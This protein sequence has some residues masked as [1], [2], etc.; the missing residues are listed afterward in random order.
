MQ[1]THVRKTTVST[2]IKLYAAIIAGLEPLA[3]YNRNNV[4]MRNQGTANK[5]ANI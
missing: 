1:I 5:I 4:G 2:P 3:K